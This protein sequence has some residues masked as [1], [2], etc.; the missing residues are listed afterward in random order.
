MRLVQRLSATAL[1]VLVVGE[2]V[3]AQRALAPWLLDDDVGARDLPA[4]AAFHV[5]STLALRCKQLAAALERTFVQFFL[6]E[7]DPEH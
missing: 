2:Q 5:S 7:L 3:L 6:A 4:F 1:R